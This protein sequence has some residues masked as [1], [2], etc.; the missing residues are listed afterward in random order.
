MTHE[1]QFP[2]HH[3][4]LYDFVKYP[5]LFCTPHLNFLALHLPDYFI[6]CI[7]FDPSI[8]FE[9]LFL[10]GNFENQLCTT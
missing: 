9:N 2:L 10:W 1:M 3:S 8:N 5:F 6:F 4:F 7:A